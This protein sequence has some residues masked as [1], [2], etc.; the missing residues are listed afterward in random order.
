[1]HTRNS[2]RNCSANTQSMSGGRIGY[3]WRVAGC[4]LQVIPNPAT[5]NPQPATRNLLLRILPPRLVGLVVRQAVLIVWN[6]VRITG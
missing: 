1:M 6:I 4:E 3:E 5:R 2:N